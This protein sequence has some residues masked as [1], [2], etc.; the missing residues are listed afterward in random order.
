VPG[1]VYPGYIGVYRRV[2]TYQGP[3][4]SRKV[5]RSRKKQKE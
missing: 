3:R 5:R 1:R 2:Y 4:R